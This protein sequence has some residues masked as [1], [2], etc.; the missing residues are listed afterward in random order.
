MP[1]RRS[2]GE[3]S[4]TRRANGLWIG[5]VQQDGV[6]YQVAS[7][8]RQERD[9]LLRQLIRD[10]EA[11]KTPATA[12]RKKT[13]GQ[14]VTEWLADRE[15]TRPATYPT[16]RSYA[17]HLLDSPLAGVVVAKLTTA[18]VLALYKSKLEA[19]YAPSTVRQVHRTLATALNWAV[20]QDVPVPAPLLKLQA[21]AVPKRARVQLTPAQAGRLFASLEER[22][23][24]LEALWVLCWYCSA[25]LGELLALTWDDV[26]LA[27]GLIGIGRVLIRVVDGEPQTRAGKTES[28]RATLAIPDTA[29]AVLRRQWRA[30]EERRRVAGRAWKEPQIGRLVVDRGDGGAL[31]HEQAEQ[32]FYQA[33]EAASL[34]RC[35]PHDLRGASLSALREAGHDV[36]DVQKRARHASVATTLEH[37][38][39]GSDAAD[40]RA[41]ETLERLV[42]GATS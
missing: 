8:D 12:P 32:A 1:R 27:V 4:R 38:V 23:D 37:Y 13:L 40:R 9:R 34:P 3:G 39:R 19:G 5:R 6:R 11:G 29:T 2:P 14:V 26:N 33:L 17:R 28:S 41:A 18:E 36:L 24:P 35:R 22:R 21:P 15:L 31:R 16:W 25:R 10:L 7:M 30:Q 42:H 20:G